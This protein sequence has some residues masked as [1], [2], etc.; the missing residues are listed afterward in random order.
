M[1]RINNTTTFPITA[2]ASDDLVIG[3]DVSDTTNSA[4]G[5]TVNFK[6]SDILGLS[7]TA[8]EFVQVYEPDGTSSSVDFALPDSAVFGGV[9]F[10]LAGIGHGSGTD[11]DLTMRFSTDGGSTFISSGYSTVGLSAP[12]NAAIYVA[13]LIDNTSGIGVSGVVRVHGYGRTDVRTTVTS[14]LVAESGTAGDINKHNTGGQIDVT[15][16]V[17]H[18]RFRISGG[19]NMRDGHIIMRANK[20]V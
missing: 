18:V 2:P 12:D 16:A 8:T 3:T 20:I 5:E 7:P 17:T 4:D 15:T 14:D 1:A 6:F 13:T 11:R 19:V 9:V 10:E